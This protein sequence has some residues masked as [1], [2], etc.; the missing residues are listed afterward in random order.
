MNMLIHQTWS[1][2]AVSM[3]NTLAT[4]S[5]FAADLA[6]LSAIEL[7]E[8][9]RAYVDEPD[10]AKGRSCAAFVR[11]FIEGSPEIHYCA[12]AWEKEQKESFSDR[13]LRTRLGVRPH[14]TPLYCL[15]SSVSLQNF[16]ASIVSYIDEHPS[17]EGLTA[18]DVL[19]GTLRRSYRCER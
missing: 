4:F 2:M 3:L 11:G 8:R 14:A 5:L 6:P 9:C 18:S 19:Y 16:I 17:P 1:V 12:N 7:H 13:A 15:D 10:S